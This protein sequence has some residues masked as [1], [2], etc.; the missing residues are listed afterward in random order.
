MTIPAYAMV[1]VTVAG[2]YFSPS[3]ARSFLSAS[4]STLASGASP[5]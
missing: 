3:L 5:M 2:A 4:W 1:S